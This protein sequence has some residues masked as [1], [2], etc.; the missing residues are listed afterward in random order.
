M[1]SR[2]VTGEAAADDDDADADV[3]PEALEPLELLEEQPAMRRAP[4]TTAAVPAKMARIYLP[5][6]IGLL[7]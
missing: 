3:V 6:P 7:G 5:F 4:P 1:P 2:T